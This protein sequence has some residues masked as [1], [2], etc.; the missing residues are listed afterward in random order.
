[1]SNVDINV[2]AIENLE[3]DPCEEINQ[4][5][6]R[7]TIEGTR[8]LETGLLKD[9]SG[10][11]TAIVNGLSEQLV[12]QVNL[13]IPDVLVRFD[14]LNVEL[15][16]AV[17]PFLQ[18]PAKLAL[19][20][21]IQDRGQTLHINSAYRTLAQ[22]L[23]LKQ[24]VGSCGI[25]IAAN[26][27]KSN[28]QGG[29]AIDVPDPEDWRPYL[30]NQGWQW[31][32]GGDRPHFDYIGDETQDIRDSAILAFQQLW[33][34]NNPHAPIDEDSQFGDETEDKLMQSPID[35]FPLA[36]W[37]EK[38]RELRLSRP[39][40]HGSDVRKVQEALV[41][42]GFPVTVDNSFGKDI[43]AAVKQFQK[44]NGLKEDGIVGAVTRDR[45]FNTKK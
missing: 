2:Q 17:W 27:G 18:L 34:K 12:Y 20:R 1:M 39:I 25:T 41:K 42:A 30:E 8:G 31:F 36:P 19:E 16:N 24:W 21:A 38:P 22:Q 32:G 33:N 23:L 45:L 9:A 7:G 26:V 3:V 35:G 11:T 10:C 43:D 37:D 14:D 40:M 29:L 4:A 6:A 28:H 13:I 5:E 44:K 15:E